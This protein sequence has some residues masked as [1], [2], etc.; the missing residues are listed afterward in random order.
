MLVGI[1]E[2][3]VDL[4]RGWICNLW[5]MIISDVFSYPTDNTFKTVVLEH[6][7]KCAI[8]PPSEITS[9]QDDKNFCK[10]HFTFYDEGEWC[11]VYFHY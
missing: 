10:L 3:V 4:V 2:T 9:Q 6:L 11:S 1:S 8:Q 7:A 5:V